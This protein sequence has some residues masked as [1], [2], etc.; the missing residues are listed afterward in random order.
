MG[1]KLA[2]DIGAV[3]YMECSAL[4]QPQSVKSIFDEAIRAVICPPESTGKKGKKKKDK[5]KI[6]CSIL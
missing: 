1:E 2:A 5:K 6:P 3:K 4:K